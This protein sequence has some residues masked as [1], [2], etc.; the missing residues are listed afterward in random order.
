MTHELHLVEGLVEGHRTGRVGLL[1]HDHRSV[2]VHGDGS[3]LALGLGLTRGGIVVADE[4]LDHRGARERLAHR[5]RC[6]AAAVH[7]P[8]VGGSLHLARHLVQRQ[9]EGGHLVVGRRLGADDRA[10]REGGQL[11]VHGAVVLSGVGFAVDLHVDPHDPVVVLLELRQLLRAVGP[12]ALL[13]L[14]VPAG[15]HNFH[16]NLL[17][18]TR[19]AMGDLSGSWH[20]SRSRGAHRTAPGRPPEAVRPVVGTRWSPPGRPGLRPHNRLLRLSQLLCHYPPSPGCG[21]IWWPDRGRTY[22]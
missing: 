5:D 14:A 6:L 4:V 20:A 1:A 21:H 7:A 2:A 12:E 3:D 9:V 16:V 13:D 10:L 8:S 15:D 17:V 18:R 22:V 19:C 11:H